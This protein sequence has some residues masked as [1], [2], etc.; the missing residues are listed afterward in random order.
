MG[1]ATETNTWG[2]SS[3]LDMTPPSDSGWHMARFG[4]WAGGSGAVSQVYNFY[5]DPY[6]RG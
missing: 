6:S 3:V 5:V 2:P 1:Q 4:F